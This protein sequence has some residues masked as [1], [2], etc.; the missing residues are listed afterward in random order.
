MNPRVFVRDRKR[1]LLCEVNSRG[2]FVSVTLN[3]PKSAL[4]F[5]DFIDSLYRV[6][7][8]CL[9]SSRAALLLHN[10]NRCIRALGVTTVR[11]DG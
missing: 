9:P 11:K 3:T 2:L 10:V 8:D 5:D 4:L 1:V 7:H 6:G